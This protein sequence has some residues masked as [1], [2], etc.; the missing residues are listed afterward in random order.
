MVTILYMAPALLLSR[1]QKNQPPENRMADGV[2][3]ALF[4][5]KGI[6]DVLHP[7][8]EGDHGLALIAG[9]NLQVSGGLQSLDIGQGVIRSDGHDLDFLGG[10]SAA[11]GLQ[12]LND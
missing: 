12:A 3:G 7:L 11:G 8:I 9:G 5:C 4:L 1:N 2:F 10:L 6:G